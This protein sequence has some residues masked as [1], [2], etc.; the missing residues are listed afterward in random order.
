MK[1]TVRAVKGKGMDFLKATKADN[2]PRST[3]ND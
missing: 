1:K 3:L 2:V